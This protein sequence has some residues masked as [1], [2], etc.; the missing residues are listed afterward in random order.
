MNGIASLLDKSATIR[1]ELLWQELEARC[2]LV[3]IKTTPFPHISW[4]VTDA[5]DLKHLEKAL[6]TFAKQSQ[7]FSVRSTGLGV[8]TGDHP[9][10]FISILKDEPLMRF[11]SLLWEQT[12]RIAIRPSPYYSPILWVPHITIAY[13]DVDQRNLDCA[14]Q[15]LAF[16]NFDWE[17]QIDNLVFIAQTE[18]QVPETVK[19]HLGNK[20]INS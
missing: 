12:N 14:M 18:N 5:Y 1:V 4:Q 8:F 9:I 16:Q 15:Y 6:E 7:P 11:Q 10:L 17:I 19:Y 3:G 13:N 20:G 2:G